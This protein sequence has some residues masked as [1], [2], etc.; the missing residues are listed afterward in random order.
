[1]ENKNWSN[2]KKGD[3]IFILVPFNRD[4]EIQYDS[5]LIKN[6][7]CLQTTEVIT[8]KPYMNFVNI[9]LKYTDAYGKRQRINVQINK[10][11]FED[12]IVSAEKTS[13]YAAHYPFDYGQILLTFKDRKVLIDEFT[14]LLEKHKEYIALKIREYQEHLRFLNQ[15]DLL[16]EKIE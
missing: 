15:N 10:N 13:S 14:K 5:D 7:M 2:L 16:Y 6:Y 12:D 3:R 4:E 9:R 1:M 8:I 11:K